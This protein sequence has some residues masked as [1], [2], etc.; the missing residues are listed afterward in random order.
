MSTSTES[1]FRKGGVSTRRLPLGCRLDRYVASHFLRSYLLA[2]L[3]MSGLFMVIDMASILDDYLES[4]E[5]GSSAP[6]SRRRLR[7]V[8]TTYWSVRN[9]ISPRL[10]H[11][12][13]TRLASHRLRTRALR[14]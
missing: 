8:G 1:P 14:G 4:W 6:A 9:A 10:T 13:N 5:D 3:R 7:M 11:S 2:M 12:S